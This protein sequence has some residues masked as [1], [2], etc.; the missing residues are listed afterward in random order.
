MDSKDSNR[1]D[2]VSNRVDKVSNRVDNKASNNSLKDSSNS[3][4]N[5]KVANRD[6][7]NFRCN[8]IPNKVD[9]NNKDTVSA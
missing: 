6:I 5:N 3:H 7:N 2:K 1:V 9:F 8:N 4:T